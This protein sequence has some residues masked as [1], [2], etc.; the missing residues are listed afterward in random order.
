MG[1]VFKGGESKE[2]TKEEF[3]K[4]SY[5]EF[6]KY[7]EGIEGQIRSEQDP[8]KQKELLNGLLNVEVRR[9][10]RL[11]IPAMILAQSVP[12][13]FGYPGWYFSEFLSREDDDYKQDQLKGLGFDESNRGISEG[14]SRMRARIETEREFMEK[15]RIGELPSDWTKPIPHKIPSGVPEADQADLFWGHCGRR[16]GSL[17]RFELEDDVDSMPVDK[18]IDIM[19][20]HILEYFFG[21]GTGIEP[22]QTREFGSDKEITREQIQEVAD[23]IGFA[24]MVRGEE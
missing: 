18:K 19:I 15:L 17:L 9:E 14:E 5:G 10:Q 11:A 24:D 13:K 1:E 4:M 8:I 21:D 20:D 6:R 22:Y 23:E 7:Q 3:R 2:P 12:L 16:L